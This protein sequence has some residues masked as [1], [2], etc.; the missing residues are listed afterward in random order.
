MRYELQALDLLI[1]A[2]HPARFRSYA[3]DHLLSPER[4]PTSHVVFAMGA[5]QE[6]IM[7][8][9]DDPNGNLRRRSRV[10]DDGSSY[11]GWIIG[12]IVALAVIIGIFVTMSRNNNPNTAANSPTQPQVNT[13]APASTPAPSTTG[14]GAAAPARAAQ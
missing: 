9:Q 1:K 11:T 8:Y 13:A 4:G 14:S 7:T 12:G 3:T 2:V 5:N 6:K 10:G